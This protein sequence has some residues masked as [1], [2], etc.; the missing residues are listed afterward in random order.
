MACSLAGQPDYTP[1]A[2]FLLYTEQKPNVKIQP[3]YNF[4]TARF[5]QYKNS[6]D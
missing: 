5:K 4:K 3:V 1:P 6:R 2:A